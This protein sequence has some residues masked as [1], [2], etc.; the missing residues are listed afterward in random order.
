MDREKAK[1]LNDI[2]GMVISF[3]IT[4]IAYSIFKGTNFPYPVAGLVT[5][6]V[7]SFGISVTFLNAVDK[8]N[9]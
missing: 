5:I 7:I 8:I 3:I 1:K 9:R 6:F 2:I 4:L